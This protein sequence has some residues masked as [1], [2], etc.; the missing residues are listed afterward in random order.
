MERPIVQA[1]IVEDSPAESDL[2]E[3]L[4]SDNCLVRVSGKAGSAGKG[5][6]MIRK[7]NPEQVFSN[8]K[9]HA[10]N[11]VDLLNKMGKRNITNK[12]DL[13]FSNEY[14]EDG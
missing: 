6:S 9:L 4:S 7:S 11:A 1:I 3:A 8:N 2:Q 14:Q 13:L 5:L 12:W 10:G